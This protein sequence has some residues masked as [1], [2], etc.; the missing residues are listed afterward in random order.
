MSTRC[1]CE[2]DGDEF[3]P[4]IIVRSAKM[5]AR[6]FFPGHKLPTKATVCVYGLISFLGKARNKITAHGGDSKLVV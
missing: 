2:K 1:L 6:R 3:C 5:A 4:D